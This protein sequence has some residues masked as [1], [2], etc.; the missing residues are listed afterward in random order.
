MQRQKPSRNRVDNQGRK[1]SEQLKH[2]QDQSQEISPEIKAEKSGM[3]AKKE[4]VET[5]SEWSG[6]TFR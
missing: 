5:G 2:R 4:E 3:S 6:E 1:K